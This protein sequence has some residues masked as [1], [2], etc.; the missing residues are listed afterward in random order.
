MLKLST[1]LYSTNQKDCSETQCY[2]EKIQ[3]EIQWKRAKKPATLELEEYMH[4]KIEILLAEGYEKKIAEQEVIKEVGNP[5]KIGKSL[6]DV[7]HPRFDVKLFLCMLSLMLVGAYLNICCG[8]IRTIGTTLFINVMGML[9]VIVSYFADYTIVIRKISTF[10]TYGIF[11]MI[12]TFWLDTRNGFG[13]K[14]YAYSL[15]AGIVF[16]VLVTIKIRV[17]KTFK[18]YIISQTLSVMVLYIMMLLQSIVGIILL[19]STMIV[20]T[21]YISKKVTISSFK[22]VLIIEPI[23]AFVIGFWI[24]DGVTIVEKIFK[25]K[26]LGYVRRIV[27]SS[28]LIGANFVEGMQLEKTDYML[29]YFIV[30]YGLIAAVF[31]L[32]IYIVIMANLQWIRRK[33]SLDV[34]KGILSYI[35]LVFWVQI[36]GAYINA[37]G[38]IY[39]GGMDLPFVSNGMCFSFCDYL[40]FGLVMSMRRHEDI[41]VDLIRL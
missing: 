7:H 32:I 19:I 21:I 30:G 3:D 6:N 39:V 9:V 1:K 37:F 34:N 24:F 25:I 40:L 16:M 41:V 11:L 31:L 5:M 29:D 23:I 27:S 17:G 8:T 13:A 20:N 22:I 2:I 12:V 14:P 35:I 10:T 28:R 18:H 36:I 4:D 33:Q 26:E 15:F 38:L